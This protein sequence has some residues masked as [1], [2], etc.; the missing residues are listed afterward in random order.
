MD[1]EQLD[2]MYT[3]HAQIVYR[4]LYS[5]CRDALLAEELTQ[6]TFYRAVLS[7]NRYD[8]S[9]KLSTW[10]CQIAR[11]MWY[12]HLAKEKKRKLPLSDV[13]SRSIASPEELHIQKESL[14][15][16]MGIIDS[17]KEPYSEVVRLRVLG[18]LSFRNI[19]DALGKS[20][21]WARVTYFRGKK[22]IQDR[23]LSD[24]D[25]L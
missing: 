5:L 10:L 20:E 3:D 14:N 23:R 19:G 22:M 13:S 2:S 6:E 7:I 25:K 11:H 15:R 8:H 4:F 9:C 17:L 16:L 1:N 18:D 24:E 12:Q 21:T